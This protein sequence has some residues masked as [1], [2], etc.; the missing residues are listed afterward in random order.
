MSFASLLSENP[1]GYYALKYS[2]FHFHVQQRVAI[3]QFLEELTDDI[4]Q[5]ELDN[6]CDAFL[7][8]FHIA[9]QILIDQI[10]FDWSVIGAV[11]WEQYSLSV[12]LDSCYADSESADTFAIQTLQAFGI[13]IDD[14]SDLAIVTKLAVC[15]YT[16]EYFSV[17]SYSLYDINVFFYGYF[18]FYLE[19]FTISG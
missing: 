10:S 12:H 17:S 3:V 6:I 18:N 7:V 8:D 5:P 4:T 2:N 14:D 9:T 19:W 11:S 13:S 15:A 1:A 16:T